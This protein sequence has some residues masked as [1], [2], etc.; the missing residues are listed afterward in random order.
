[1]N[2]VVLVIAENAKN[3]HDLRQGLSEAKDGPFQTICATSLADA[4]EVLG[5]TKIDCILIDLE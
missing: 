4:I 2:L 1:M 5:D 3:L